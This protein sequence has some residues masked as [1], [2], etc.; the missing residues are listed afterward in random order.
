MSSRDFAL[1]VVAAL[2]LSASGCRGEGPPEGLPTAVVVIESEGKELLE[3]DV[4]VADTAADRQRGLMGV[5]NLRG[6]GMAFLFSEPTVTPFFMR[7][8]L[9]ALQ[10][11]SWDVDGRIVSIMD[12]QPCKKEPCP[13]YESGEEIVGALEVPLGLLDQKGVKLG[14]RVTISR[15]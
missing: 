13:L 5:T 6:S 7:D 15:R 10:I 14:D 3:M 11:A 4:V 1:L 9:I 12:M 2:A 8:T